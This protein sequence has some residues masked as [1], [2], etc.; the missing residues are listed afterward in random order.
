[1]C[2]LGSH[3]FLFVLKFFFLRFD[4]FGNSGPQIII[5]SIFFFNEYEQNYSNLS[6][7]VVM[8]MCENVLCL[9]SIEGKA[10]FYSHWFYF[11]VCFGLYGFFNLDYED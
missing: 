5:S 4:F 7:L 2:T 3:L 9:E 10:L 1:M 6:V 8:P 11:F